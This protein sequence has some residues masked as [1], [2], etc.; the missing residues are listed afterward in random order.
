VR[1]R[2][3]ILSEPR[4]SPEIHHRSAIAWN[5][6]N[7]I[8]AISRLTVSAPI[9]TTIATVT[10]GNLLSSWLMKSVPLPALVAAS[11]TLLQSTVAAEKASAKMSGP[12]TASHIGNPRTNRRR[13]EPSKRPW[14]SP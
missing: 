2:E 3:R 12:I 4:R 10:P 11:P 5:T 9:A 8:A 14:R 1:R 6:G 7:R 13:A